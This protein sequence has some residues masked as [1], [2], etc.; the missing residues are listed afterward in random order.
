MKSRIKKAAEKICKK[1]FVSTREV[2][3][4]F[5]TQASHKRIYHATIYQTA[6]ILCG[7][8]VMEE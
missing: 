3:L 1:G 6:D 5:L 4:H 2:L 7:Y 8:I